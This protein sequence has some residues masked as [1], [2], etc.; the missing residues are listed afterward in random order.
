MSL[1]ELFV[2]GD[3]LDGDEPPAGLVLGDR[4]DEQRRKPVAEAVEEDGDVDGRSL[5]TGW[6]TLGVCGA[7]GQGSACSLATHD[8]SLVP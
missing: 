1:E 5:A 6:R 7:S 4:V 8:R 2:D 3:V